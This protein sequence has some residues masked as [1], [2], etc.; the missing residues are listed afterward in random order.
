MPE[1]GGKLTKF[2]LGAVADKLRKFGANRRE[3]K[4]RKQAAF[5]VKAMKPERVG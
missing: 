4:A 1:L 2:G 5:E 3:E